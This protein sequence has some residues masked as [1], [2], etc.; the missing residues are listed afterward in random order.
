MSHT[1]KV[2]GVCILVFLHCLYFGKSTPCHND[3]STCVKQ[4]TLP[5]GTQKATVFTNPIKHH[6]YTTNQA[7]NYLCHLA[8]PWKNG[9]VDI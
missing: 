4:Q 2:L 8:F 6:N 5:T 7:Y 3:E 9:D 1:R